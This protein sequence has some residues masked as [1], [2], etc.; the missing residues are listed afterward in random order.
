MLTASGVVA[1]YVACLSFLHTWLSSSFGLGTLFYLFLWLPSQAFIAKRDLSISA[2]QTRFF[3]LTLTF[4]GLFVTLRT[5]HID[6]SLLLV[7]LC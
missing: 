7:F 5:L 4:N 2:I 1:M 3:S 6:S